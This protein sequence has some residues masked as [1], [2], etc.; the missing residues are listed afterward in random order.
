MACDCAMYDCQQRS[1]AMDDKPVVTIRPPSYQPSKAEIEE[2]V[3]VDA[4][5]EA[6]RA[7]LMRSVVVKESDDA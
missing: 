6:V 7:A 4:T 1:L 3:S 5:P 2:D